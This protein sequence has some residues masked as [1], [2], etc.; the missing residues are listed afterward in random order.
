L[1]GQRND[2]EAPN[3]DLFGDPLNINGP[4]WNAGNLCCGEAQRSNIDDVGFIK[5]MISAIAAEVSIDLR[6][7]YATG[8]SNG[9]ALAHRLACDAADV[10]AAFAP[11]A[12]PIAFD[13]VEMCKPSRPV[14][15]I[16]FQG[17]TDRLI[18]YEGGHIMG[19][20]LAPVIPS[21]RASF[22]YWRDVNGCEGEGPD[23]VDRLGATSTLE[24]YTACRDGVKV[25]LATVR[26]IPTVPYMG[27]VLYFN[28]DGI[29]L[30][31]VAWDFMF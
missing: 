10:F 26:G 17:D 5:A 1:F 18:P 21:A 24:T 23:Q 6:R 25:A 3:G 22:N 31:R 11:F 2:P 28:I 14:P 9:G 16:T 12:F 20:P 29:N 7:V 19:H 4:S 30:A 13:P 27:H 15:I 8:L